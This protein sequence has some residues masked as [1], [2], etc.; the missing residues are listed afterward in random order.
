MEKLQKE[1]VILRRLVFAM[2][3]L[4]IALCAFV[5]QRTE[6]LESE[7]ANDAWNTSHMVGDNVKSEIKDELFQL[8]LRIQHLEK[9]LKQQ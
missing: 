1:V 3:F 5:W 2:L 8:D 7:A 9:I 4:F 6:D